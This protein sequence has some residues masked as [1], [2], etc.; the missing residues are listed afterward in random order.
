MLKVFTLIL[1]VFLSFSDTKTLLLR[2][3]EEY[4]KLGLKVH[5]FNMEDGNIPSYHQLF[6]SIETV[7][8]VIASG[9]MLQRIIFES[10]EGP[11]FTKRHPSP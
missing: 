5:H 1:K 7:K 2:L 8:S 4:S 11:N 9:V 10:L 6:T 3:S